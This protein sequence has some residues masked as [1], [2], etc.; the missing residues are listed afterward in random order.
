MNPFQIIWQS[1]K[2][3]YEELFR[4]LLMGFITL[5]ALILILPGPAA[6]GGLWGVAQRAVEGYGIQWS[7]YWEALKRYGPRNWLNTLVVAVIYGLIALNF[8]FYNTPGISPVS[9]EIALIAT[10]FWIGMTLI[11]TGAVFYWLSFQL[12]MTE[13]KFWLSL[14][15][16]VFLVFVHPFKTLVFLIT[17]GLLAALCVVI[18]PLLILFP[19][20]TAVMSITAVKTLIKP[21]LE[22]HKQ[23][24]EQAPS[25]PS[26]R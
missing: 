1:M 18:P 17:T 3:F 19:G 25:H 14:R 9:A 24:Q 15:N 6:L 12:E 4:F 2:T 10:S 23:Q 11:W 8:W 7:D 13:P 22:A 21:L 20:F 5:L 26:E 16:S